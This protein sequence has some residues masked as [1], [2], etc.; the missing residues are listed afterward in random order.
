MTT[1][2]ALGLKYQKVEK[3]NNYKSNKKEYTYYV[4]K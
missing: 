3:N 4:E 2:N 1:P